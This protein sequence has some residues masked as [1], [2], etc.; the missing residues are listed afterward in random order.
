VSHQGLALSQQLSH[1]IGAHDVGVSHHVTCHLTHHMTSL[2]IHHMICMW[3]ITWL[4]T[5]PVD[6]EKENQKYMHCKIRKN[7]KNIL[8]DKSSQLSLSKSKGQVI[9]YMMHHVQV[10]WWIMWLVRWWVRCLSR[11]GWLMHHVHLL[12][13]SVANWVPSPDDSL[14]RMLFLIADM[15]IVWWLTAY[16][17]WHVIVDP[18]MY[19]RLW[20]L[21]WVP[22]ST[23]HRES[24]NLFWPK[25]PI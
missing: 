1:P 8:W 7:E 16:E 2:M 12:D 25:T 9:S 4:I 17:S 20:L 24:F 21:P 18:L 23:S 13:D 6:L 11:D 14:L 15:L 3:H 19:K 5:W 22:I 10:M